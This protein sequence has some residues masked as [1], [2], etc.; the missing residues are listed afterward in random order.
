M[1]T[2]WHLSI[3]FIVHVRAINN[4]LRYNIHF[5]DKWHLVAIYMAIKA[6]LPSHFFPQNMCSPFSRINFSCKNF[7]KNMFACH[8]CYRQSILYRVLDYIA[9]IPFHQIR[10][11]P[12]SWP[13]FSP[14]MSSTNERAALLTCTSRLQPYKTGRC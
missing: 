11:I 6:S 4:T 13:V 3:K 9:I 10:K 2:R 14:K 8:R 12:N 7:Y 5:I 1:A